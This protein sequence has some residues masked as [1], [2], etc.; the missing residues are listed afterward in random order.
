MSLTSGAPSSSQP[1]RSLNRQVVLDEDEYTEALSHIIKRDF[2][3]SLVHLDATNDYLDALRSQD[4]TLIQASVRRLEDLQTPASHRTRGWE[5][6]PSQ[7][8]YRAG[9]SDTPLRTPRGADGEAP[10]K[11]A[12]YDTDMSLD[13]FQARYTSE[14]N[15]SFTQILDAEN[16]RRREKYGWAW[17]AQRRVEEQRGRMI[18]SRERMLIEPQLGAGVKERFRVEAATPAGLIEAAPA[19]PEVVYEKE[20]DEVEDLLDGTHK[21]PATAE[22]ADSKGKGKAKEESALVKVAKD[23]QEV[24]DVMAPKKDTRPA[25]VD[26]WKFRARNALMFPPDAD[27]SPYHPPPVA[28]AE[29]AKGPPKAIKHTNTR[30]PEQDDK[31]DHSISA[32]PSPTRSRIDAAIAGTPYRPRSPTTDT[33]S[34]VPSIPSPTPSELGPA[35]VKQLMTWGTLNATPRVL[36]QSDDPADIPTPATPFRIAEPSSRERLSHK[37]S[38]DAAKSLRA[39]AGLLGGIP[40]LA[41]SSGSAGGLRNG[42]MPPPSWTPRKAEAPGSLTP[43]ARRLLDRT[44][45]GTAAARRADAMG[46]LSG[47]ESNAD[48]ARERDLQKVRWTPTPS[49]V[50]RRG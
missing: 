42:S 34:L 33:H 21:E 3:P 9:P 20:E 49:P 14:D 15:S 31:P 23:D 11:R 44:T 7:T 39:K 37:L 30:L 19:E 27:V 25:G 43:A 24:V 8:P 4:P 36:S 2:F 16:R 47:W 28:K 18:E 6:T 50:T 46:R 26:G 17:E 40:G 5:A 13:A 45:M 10:A 41:R 12:R 32:P 38:N 1:T 48:R 29:D 22:Q 35:A